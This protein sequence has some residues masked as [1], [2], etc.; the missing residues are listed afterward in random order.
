V[1]DLPP[2]EL[3]PGS[4]RYLQT[5]GD[6]L[7]DSTV[8]RTL[9]GIG[10]LYASIHL[11]WEPGIAAEFRSLQDAGI[12]RRQLLD[13]VV[14]AQISAGIRGLQHVYSAVGARLP[15]LRDGPDRAAFPPGWAPDPAAFACGLDLTTAELSP[16]D[17]TALEHWFRA[18]I[19]YVPDAVQFAARHHPRFLK[20]QRSKWE[21]AL[22][23]LPKQVMPYLMLGHATLTGSAAGLRDAALL[24]RTWGMGRPWA[25]H[26]IGGC[27][28]NFTGLPMLELA[29]D[30]L[31]DILAEWDPNS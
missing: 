3:W 10:R 23:T 24:G 15:E 8:A 16:T 17:Q 22:R 27:A 4:T 11:G 5:S 25:L 29:H 21:A 13:I 14:T 30:A 18:T 26:A 19:G 1:S 7:A 9:L 20:A 31:I 12:Q 28:Y 2:P 6:L